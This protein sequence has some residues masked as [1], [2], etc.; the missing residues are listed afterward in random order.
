MLS[1]L[2]FIITDDWGH[3]TFNI[4]LDRWYKYYGGD[5]AANRYFIDVKEPESYRQCLMYPTFSEY[6][7]KNAA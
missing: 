5:K 2:F 7:K 1:R 4:V 6:L 3:E